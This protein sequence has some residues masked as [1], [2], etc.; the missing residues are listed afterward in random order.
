VLVGVR[1]RLRGFRTSHLVVKKSLVK[2][3]KN[4]NKKTYM[5]H[6]S[7]SPVRPGDAGVGGHSSSYL[8]GGGRRGWL[9]EHRW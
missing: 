3:K 8:E 5:E 1:R 9:L 2:P 4:E 7:L 6:D